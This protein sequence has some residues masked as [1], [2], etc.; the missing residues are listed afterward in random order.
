MS[1]EMKEKIVII[2][3]PVGPQADPEIMPYLPIT[4]EEIAEESFKCY[5][6]GASMVHVH[7]RDVETRGV[8][9]DISVL[10]EIIKRIRG[11]CNVLIQ[12]TGAMGGGRDPKTGKWMRPTEEQRLPLLDLT[13][14]PD[15]ISTPMGTMD[16]VYPGGYATSFNRPD[17]LKKMIPGIIKK[18]WAWETEIWDVSFLHNTY[19]LAEEGVFDKNM[20][21]WLHYCLGDNN[22]VQPSNPRHLLYLSEEGKRLFPHA[23]WQVTARA[24]NYWQM[25][26]TGIVLGCDIARVGF[27][28][29]FR[30]P[31]G[32]I[33]R[34]TVQMVEAAVRIVRALGKEVATVEEAK[35]ILS[36]RK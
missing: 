29:H 26:A 32:E 33:A 13:P 35:K 24:K 19:R 7:A 10:A 1:S 20:P 17:F 12:S 23:I 14:E 30:L 8:S 34:N 27:E 36:I 11:K 15:A 21:M 31:N 3:A 5:Q 2:A 9:F 6:S 18:K 16:Y 25:L 4:Q 28:D 22:G